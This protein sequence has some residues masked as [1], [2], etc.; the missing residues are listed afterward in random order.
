MDTQPDPDNSFAGLF[1][2]KAMEAAKRDYKERTHYWLVDNGS[3]EGD[4]D[5]TL[6]HKH[7]GPVAR[8]LDAQ[9][10]VVELIVH[11]MN[12]RAE[13]DEDWEGLSQ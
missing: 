12:E 9:K 8:I 1:T 10:H 2:L 11:A 6:W 5:V 4:C 3:I 13:R 7:Q